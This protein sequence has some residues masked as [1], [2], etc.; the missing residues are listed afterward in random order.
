MLCIFWLF[1]STAFTAQKDISSCINRITA[2]LAVTIYPG[3]FLAWLISMSAL[4]NSRFVIFIFYIMVFMNDSG[5][6]FLG[7][8]FGKNNRGFVPASPNKSIAGFAGGF[9]ASVL[10]G[11]AAVIFI[12]DAFSSNLLPSIPA[13]VIFGLICGAASI[14]GDLAE[15]ALKRSAVIKD[16]GFLIVGRGGVLDSVDSV[17]L[18]AP[19]YYLLYYFLFLS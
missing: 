8:L 9:L 3:V 4:P 5:A 15:S 10:T 13:G 7:V 19:V 1:A 2:G 11:I 16:S 6:W 14:L 12:P 17:A 18:A